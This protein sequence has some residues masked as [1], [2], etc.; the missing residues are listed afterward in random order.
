MFN[1]IPKN[2]KKFKQKIPTLGE[3][4][5]ADAHLTQKTTRCI[6]SIDY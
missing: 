2:R 6:I 3:K 4:F 5:G 1:I